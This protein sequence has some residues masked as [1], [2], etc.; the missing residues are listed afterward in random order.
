MKS[1]NVG[2]GKRAVAVLRESDYPPGHSFDEC[3]E[4][5]YLRYRVNFP[6][7]PEVPD[8]VMYKGFIERLLPDGFDHYNEIYDGRIDVLD[9]DGKVVRSV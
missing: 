5:L 6:M 1:R 8:D 7:N 4:R 2:K 9:D 3:P